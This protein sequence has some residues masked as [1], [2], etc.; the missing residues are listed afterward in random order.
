MRRLN[1][2]K[3]DEIAHAIAQDKLLWFL[4]KIGL[5]ERG[6][7]ANDVVD[8]LRPL[9][10]EALEG[11]AIGVATQLSQLSGKQSAQEHLGAI[12][13]AVQTA[14]D[15]LDRAARPLIEKM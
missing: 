7:D 6:A 12:I 5:N 11:A 1:T 3:P 9:E 2:N 8:A 13:P 15:D 4:I 14:T 10:W